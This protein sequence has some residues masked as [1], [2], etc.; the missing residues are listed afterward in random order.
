MQHSISCTKYVLYMQIGV[1]FIDIAF[2]RFSQKWCSVQ[3][4]EY[5]T[6]AKSLCWSWLRDVAHFKEPGQIIYT[7]L[8]LSFSD[9]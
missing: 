2:H 8:C 6:L 3:Y 7:L 4:L 5:N 9:Y 1:F